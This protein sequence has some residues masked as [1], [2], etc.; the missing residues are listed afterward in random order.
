[1]QILLNTIRPRCLFHS[2]GG[3]LYEI[4]TGG[5]EN[6]HHEGAN[7]TVENGQDHD[8]LVGVLENQGQGGVLAGGAG[9]GDAGVVVQP[10]RQ[11]GDQ[12][13]GKQLPH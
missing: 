1:M 4:E 3:V 13:K 9:G 10:N 5:D 7:H 2:G 12:H 6:W 8:F 11:N